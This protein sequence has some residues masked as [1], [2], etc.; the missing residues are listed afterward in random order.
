FTVGRGEAADFRLQDPGFSRIHFIIETSPTGFV[1]VDEGSLN[2]TFLNQDTER[3]SRV[4]LKGG[5]EI[6]IAEVRL[7]VEI[8]R[9]QQAAVSEEAT[10]F[11]PTP[12]PVVVGAPAISAAAEPSTTPTQP[13]IEDVRSRSASFKDRLETIAKQ[14]GVGL[15]LFTVPGS[16]RRWAALLLMLIAAVGSYGFI[17]LG[18]P[19]AFSAGPVTDDHAEWENECVTCHPAWGVQPTNAT[20]V[21]ADCHANVLQVRENVRDDCVSCHTEH[22]GREFNI[23]G[24]KDQCWS[25]HEGGIGVRRYDARP[26]Q[27]FYQQITVPAGALESQSGKVVDPLRQETPATAEAR[28]AVLQSF[29]AEE[30]G[31]KYAHAKHDADVLREDNTTLD[32]QDCHKQLP[33]GQIRAF[34]THAEC[35]DCH[36]E[37]V[38]SDPQKAKASASEQCLLCHTQQQGGITRVQK[39]AAIINFSHDDHTETRCVQ[40]HAAIE[41]EQEYRPVLRSAVLYPV[42]MEACYSCHEQKKATVA[43]LDCHR[44]HH[45]Y[46]PTTEAELAGGWLDSVTLGSVLL[47]FVGLVAGA[48]AYTYF[49]MRLTRRW[50]DSLM[51]PP[52]DAPPGGGPAGTPAPDGAPAA[53]APV[54]QGNILSFP[55][56]DAATCI[57]CHSCYDSCPTK[58]LA[59]DPSTHKSTVVSP[60]S[61]KALEGCTICQ[62]GCPTGAIRV[63]SGPVVREVERAHIDEHNESNLPGMFLVGEVVG[64][65]LIKKAVNQGDRAVRY[66]F[67]RK[68]R[69]AEAPYDVIVV[70]AGPAGLG[71]GLEAKRLGLRYLVLERGTLA[72]TIQDYPRDKAVLAEPVML[73]QYG[74]LPM[75]DAQKE[76]LIAA[77]EQ[78]VRESQLQLNV[79]EEVTNIQKT[80]NLFTVTT[81]KG[82]YQG[83][84]V[85]LGIG[86]RGN[87]RKIGI[88]G[89]N[90]P[91]VAY[92]LIDAADFKGKKVLVVG[93]GDSAIEAAVAL[94][95]QEGTTVTLSYRRGEFSRIKPRNAEAIKEQEQAGRITVIFNSHVTAIADKSVT[96]K[97]G[98]EQR[99]LENDAIFA[100]IGAD[101]P[102]AWLEKVGVKVEMVKETVG[103]QW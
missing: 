36:K 51:P 103:P 53:P 57:S 23:T 82:Q 45:S 80:D 85:I 22:R 16:P 71:A 84:Y 34:P 60:Q 97:V 101:P 42:P 35:I 61:C 12:P 10:A 70:G 43:C 89:E 9:S 73:S 3:A 29:N 99:E 68:P 1:L 91:K 90:V 76:S 24:G 4:A 77:W 96:L 67:N 44:E 17:K 32:C 2:G 49:D 47:M 83:A 7:K 11:M 38:D 27:A 58:V 75:K 72:S 21:T 54:A 66:I 92:N 31:L 55:I 33:D 37:V 79:R 65:A 95:K 62:D 41:G 14:K 40:C 46:P 20:C 26:M 52:T 13:A 100:L 94:S 87:P 86:T 50:L 93:G 48:G 19:V 74:L 39:A 56:V 88:A 63:T 8:T 59:G 30:T 69:R 6:R 81:V 18:R 78:V 28:L 25:C 5:D 15:K 102:K 64:A 98:E